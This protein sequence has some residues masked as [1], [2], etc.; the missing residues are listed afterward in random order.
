[1]FCKLLINVN[2]SLNGKKNGSSEF[3]GSICLTSVS[4]RIAHIYALSALK[5]QSTVSNTTLWSK[6]LPLLFSEYSVKTKRDATWYGGRPLP[7][8]RCVRWRPSCP[9]PPQKRGA[10]FP[11]FGPCL[12]WPDGW[13]HQDTT[14]YGGRPRPRWHCV[15]WGPRSPWKVHSPQLSAHDYCGQT[16]ERIKMPLGTEVDLVPGHIVLDGDLASP[17]RGTAPPLFSA[18]V[19]CDHTVAHLSYCW[20]LVR[21]Y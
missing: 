2:V 20:A 8:R 3:F 9:P 5:C 12:L 10:Q 16:A 17:E 19:Y 21:I 6:N 13:M 4:C 14:W 11:I 7:R 15:R 1:M 18:H